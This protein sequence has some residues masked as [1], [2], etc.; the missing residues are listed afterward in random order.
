[1]SDTLSTLPFNTQAKKYKLYGAIHVR[2]GISFSDL[3]KYIEGE[4][5]P[6]SYIIKKSLGKTQKKT[7]NFCDSHLDH[8]CKRFEPQKDQGPH[9]RLKPF[10][11]S[12]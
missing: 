2:K 9:S 10:H 8:Q 7:Q 3:N 12:K 1:M 5:H 4:I 6:V 11:I